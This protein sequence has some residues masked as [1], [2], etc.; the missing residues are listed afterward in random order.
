M[1]RVL[2]SPRELSADELMKLEQ[3]KQKWY[4]QLIQTLNTS[5]YD[6]MASPLKKTLIHLII[7]SIIVLVI[8]GL[9]KKYTKFS[10]DLAT[11]IYIGIS[12]IGVLISLFGTYMGQ[13]KI[14]ENVYL[15]MTLTRPG[16]TKYDYES[17]PVIQAQLMRNAYSRGS[18]GGG[19]L[20]SG[21]AGGVIGS[22]LASGRRGRKAGWKKF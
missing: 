9:L 7:I 11:K 3:A 13:Y 12:F 18:N 2:N 21:L 20:L 10:F 5:L 19:S 16:A 1:S 14:N 17:S 22:G 15:L 4:P 8:I 6:M